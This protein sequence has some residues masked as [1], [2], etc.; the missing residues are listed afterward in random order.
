MAWTPPAA[1]AA[2][3]TKTNFPA[4]GSISL[5]ASAVALTAFAGCVAEGRRSYAAGPAAQV[6]AT[7]V[8]QDDYDYFPGYETY[9]SRNRH[10]YVYRDGNNWVRRSAPRGITAEALMAGPSV[11]VDFH[12][13]PDQHHANM[14][15]TY[16]RNWTKPAKAQPAKPG[17][18]DND[19]EKRDADKG[20]HRGD[21]KKN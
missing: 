13:A 4:V 20:D 7:A 8:F 1:Y 10:E 14:V 12:D 2:G 5:L 6:Q 19:G 17:R 21:E 9:Y 3:M 11:R 15:R 18:P 16:P